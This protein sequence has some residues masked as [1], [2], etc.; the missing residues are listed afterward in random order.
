MDWAFQTIKF[1][2]VSVDKVPNNPVLASW[3][4]QLSCRTSHFYLPTQTIMLFRSLPLCFFLFIRNGM[5]YKVSSKRPCIWHSPV[6]TSISR[7]LSR[8]TFLGNPYYHPDAGSERRAVNSNL[9]GWAKREWRVSEL[10]VGARAI[11]GLNADGCFLPLR[12]WS[13]RCHLLFPVLRTFSL[14]I[15]RPPP[16]P[17]ALAPL[18]QSS[19]RF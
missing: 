11:R 8:A 15:T 7:E 9:C 13:S 3:M 10:G 19:F 14:A 2:F 1:I 6:S 16:S 18:S 12:K 5:P 17:S 4:D